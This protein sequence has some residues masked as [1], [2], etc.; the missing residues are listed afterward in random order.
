MTTKQTLQ[1]R[2]QLS[3]S[4][5]TIQAAT[6]DASRHHVLTY[7]SRALALHTL[8][9][10]SLRRE[11]KSVK[12]FDEVNPAPV[13]LK[14][15]HSAVGTTKDSTNKKKNST[16]TKDADAALVPIVHTL[17]LEYSQT[18][19]V[20][21]CVYTAQSIP[22]S[23]AKSKR[24]LSDQEANQAVYNVLFLEPA[25]L[26]KLVNYPG[27]VSHRLRCVFFDDCSDRLVLAV[28][29]KND[30]ASCSN[31]LNRSGAL[32]VKSH[33]PR[34]EFAVSRDGSGE[35]DSKNHDAEDFERMALAEDGPMDNH[36]DIL[37][38]SKREYK[39]SRRNSQSASVHGSA[40]ETGE[41]TQRTMLC[42]EKT[43]ASLLHSEMISLVC[44]SKRLTRLFGVGYI[45]VGGGSSA[46]VESSLVE[47]RESAEQRLELIRRVMVRDLITALTLSSC[48]TWLFTGHESG[49]LRV[50]SISISS[51]AKTRAGS[52]ELGS[53][54]L[55]P[56]MSTWHG[57]PVSSLRLS[58]VALSAA[59]GSE[60]RDQ[61]PPTEVMAITADR[62]SGV[63]KHW[64]FQAGYQRQ[65]SGPAESQAD[66]P[67]PSDLVARIDLVGSYNCDSQVP[68]K[69]SKPA[70]KKRT[71]LDSVLCTV[72]IFINIDMGSFTE[73]LLLV[74]R[75]DVI[76]V[77]KVQTVMHVLQQ[78]RSGDEIST[79]RIVEHVSAPKLV[80][81]SG[82][83][84]S[85]VRVLTLDASYQWTGKV[86]YL[87]QL[88]PP[89]SQRSTSISA[90]ECYQMDHERN[91]VVLGWTCGS[92]D[93]H[94]LDTKNRVGM[95]Q[96]P[97]L[98]AHVTAIGVVI[99]V[100]SREPRAHQQA[101]ASKCEPTRSW[102]DLLE[103]S[104]AG[105]DP[106]DHDPVSTTS[107]AEPSHRKSMVYIFA[108]TENGQIFGWKVPGS[109]N[110]SASSGSGRLLL[111]SKIRVDSAHS[112]HVVQFARLRQQQ[113]NGAE[114][115]V[116]LGADG[117]VK[118]WVVPSLS[119]L[120][121]INTATDGH[122]SMPSC[123]DIINS[124]SGDEKQ[125]LA[126]GSEDG[127]LA[128]WKLD[129]HK[130]SF[131]ELKVASHH[132]RRVTSITAAM[133]I[134]PTTQ[135]GSGHFAEFLSC[136]LD[137]TAIVWCIRE[138]R[139][140]E[141]RY[142]DIG[143][144]VVDICTVRNVAVA[145][146]AND[147]CAF[148][149]SLGAPLSHIELP[150]HSA[151]E[152]LGDTGVLSSRVEDHQLYQ[153]SLRPDTPTTHSDGE[154]EAETSTS[155]ETAERVVNVLR[156]PTSLAQ[157]DDTIT[158]PNALIT[159][160]K[161][162]TKP[163]AVGT[164][165]GRNSDGHGRSR[166]K[167]GKKENAA[168]HGD[169]LCAMLQNYIESHGTNDT[170]SAEY[171][172][173]FLSSQQLAIIK[174]PDFAIRKYLQEQKIEL[175]TRLNVYDACEILLAIQSAPDTRKGKFD[176]VQQ[177]SEIR[178]RQKQANK[179]EK[180]IVNR[181]A[182]VS[183]NILGEKFIRWEVGGNPVIGAE[184]K[185]P[186][187]ARRGD[188]Q[189][190]EST[191][192]SKSPTSA[193]I[194]VPTDQAMPP[195][196]EPLVSPSGIEKAAS[197]SNIFAGFEDDESP[198]EHQL[199][200]RRRRNRKLSVA[201]SIRFK[202]PNELPD[203]DL[204]HRL[205]LSQ[206]FKQHWSRGFCWCS[207]CSEL[208]VRWSDGPREPESA[209]CSDCNKK[210]HSLTLKK[211]DYKPHFSLRMVLGVIVEVYN[212]LMIPSHALLFKS[213]YKDSKDSYPSGDFS[214]HSTLYRV[215]TNKFGM[216]K[217]VEDKI[218]L[219]LLSATH[220]MRD[221]DAI[222]VFGEL[223]AMFAREGSSSD[224]HVPNEM[225]ALCVSCYSWFFSRAMV[226][227]GELIIGSGHD[228]GHNSQDTSMEIE[229]G[230]R[231]HW[232]FVN[233]ENA[234]LCAQE[235]LM[236]PLVSP[237]YLRS[238]L[239]HTGQYA[240]AYPT[241]PQ[242]A[243]DIEEYAGEARRAR[244]AAQWI[245]I[246]R[247][248]RL[249]VGE[250]KQ[251]HSE[252]R[253][254]E[255]T[256]FAQPLL[257]VTQSPP[258]DLRAEVIEKLRLI[259]SCFIFYDHEREGVMAIEDFTNILR[260]LRYLW[261]NENVT[262]EEAEA[263]AAG[264]V[265][266]TF[267]NT[268]L[269]ARRRFADVEGDGLI[270]Y[271]D[272]WAMLYIVGVRTLT[273]LKFRE[274]PSFCKDYKLEIAMDLHELLLCYM[275][276]SSTMMLP[277]GFQLG[278]SSLDQHAATQ[279]QRRVG[280]LHDGMFRMPKALSNSLSLQELLSSE[281]RVDPKDQIY[282]E[283]SAPALG[284]GAS[285]S[286]MDRFRP[287]TRDSSDT[288]GQQMVGAAPVVVGI[289]H[290]GP[291][292]K[293]RA[294]IS[295]SAI[296][297]DA[298]PGEAIRGQRPS[299]MQIE[300][301]LN[302]STSG[303]V[304]PA[305]EITSAFS[306]TYIQFPFVSPQQ[307]RLE[308]PSK[309]SATAERRIVG[310]IPLSPAVDEG[311]D[312]A[313][314]S[315]QSEILKEHEDEERAINAAQSHSVARRS[316]DE[317][318]LAAHHETKHA[319]ASPVLHRN[320]H[321]KSRTSSTVVTH[322]L[323]T[324]TK[325]VEAALKPTSSASV[326]AEPVKRKKSA[327]IVIPKIEK[328]AVKRKVSTSS[329][330]SEVTKQRYPVHENKFKSPE[331]VSV[332]T[333][334]SVNEP[335]PVKPL[336]PE[337]REPVQ[338]D[339]DP[340]V[341]DD[342]DEPGHPELLTRVVDPSPRLVEVTTQPRP[343][344]SVFDKTQLP[345]SDETALADTVDAYGGAEVEGDGDISDDDEA[346]DDNVDDEEV[347]DNE[348]SQDD[349]NDPTPREIS[350][351][352][353]VDLTGAVQEHV[354]AMEPQGVSVEA[355]TN[356][357][358]AAVEI[359]ILQ[360][361]Q[362]TAA[363]ERPE[364]KLS[365]PAV[366]EAPTAEVVFQSPI[367]GED[368][369][370]RRQSLSVAVE[371]EVVQE[372]TPNEPEPTK[373]SDSGY[374]PEGP[375][376]TPPSKTTGLV[377]HHSFRFSQ[378][379]AF[380]S[381]APVLNNPFRSGQWDPSN[382][383]DS[384]EER[385]IASEA[386]G[387]NVDS[388][389]DDE[390]DGERPEDMELQ[391]A[392]E[393]LEAYRAT[394]RPQMRRSGVNGILRPSLRHFGLAAAAAHHMSGSPYKRSPSQDGTNP[395]ISR[396]NTR[397]LVTATRNSE[398][399]RALYG[400]KDPSRLGEGIVVSAEAEAQMQQKWLAFFS[401][402]EAAMFSPLKQEIH[403]REEA[404]RLQE[405]LQSQLMKKRQDQQ[406][407]DTLR[408]Q[409]SRRESAVLKGSTSLGNGADK[410]SLALSAVAADSVNFRLRRMARE[411][412]QEIQNELQFGVSAQG[413]FTKVHEAQYFFFEYDPNTHGS[414][415]TLRLHVQRGEAE[416]FM[417]TDTKVPCVSDFMW[418]SVEKCKGLK[419]GDGQKLVLYSH[420][421][422]KVVASARVDSAR[423]G[424]D[425]GLIIPFF[426]SVVAVEPGT[427]FA[428]SIMT[429]GQK[430][431]P[432]RAIKMVDTLIEQFNELSKSFKGYRAPSFEVALL[433]MSSP[434]KKIHQPSRDQKNHSKEVE[435]GASFDHRAGGFLDRI[436]SRRRQSM[437]LSH[438]NDEHMSEHSDTV[439]HEAETEPD[440]A[441]ESQSEET[442]EVGEDC[443]S[444]QHLLESIGE[445]R[446]F[447]APRSKSFF[448]MGP[449]TDQ[450][451]FIQDEETNL[452]EAA[453]QYSPERLS[454]STVST[455]AEAVGSSA[456]EA[457]DAMMGERRLS[458]SSSTLLKHHVRRASVRKKIAQRLSPL[459][460]GAPSGSSGTLNNGVHSTSTPSLTTL[461][462]AKFAPK[463]VAY[464]LSSLD[465]DAHHL[466][467]S[468]AS[469][470]HP[471][472]SRK[473]NLPQVHSTS[474]QR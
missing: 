324:H 237:G 461:R 103:S 179:S 150:Q 116:S 390:D 325:P 464:S 11:I 198:S 288:R 346:Q 121:Y 440:D 71:L 219:F 115:L 175:K 315:W 154:G 17:S 213:A 355:V 52:Y 366:L 221:I 125:Y 117:M 408:L 7:D 86:C 298:L 216:Q 78:T 43:G 156:V 409:Q 223:L 239:M 44:G 47:W 129:Q 56:K 28:H 361:Q 114:R 435:D 159:S 75:D 401:N 96:D 382:D 313:A 358:T 102:G 206:C 360:P 359:F 328:D 389:F 190:R 143:A 228:L 164:S 310:R 172:T 449:T 416:V 456:Q 238:I 222:A 153:H 212:E 392:P 69:Q 471:P 311:S 211:Q 419:E 123:M 255:Q 425:D 84:F 280:G 388:E 253:V 166:K 192:A 436:E 234:L 180:T 242:S 318:E 312:A 27:P 396:R 174:R 428:L 9:L 323:E 160:S 161:F 386:A 322:A 262:A 337:P 421:L 251:Q 141:K 89:T 208:R 158:I 353:G 170:M 292:E 286:A 339:N 411:S 378:Q 119:I 423:G 267:E 171:L 375:E 319:V 25:T 431:E 40:E 4:D 31:S 274:I 195:P 70:M 462:V 20:F 320:D 62:D 454:K 317:L 100:V 340:V 231:T 191:P 291:R 249:L 140:D 266:L 371:K 258:T 132:E 185:K 110:D 309:Q 348:E 113:R 341:F 42:I 24:R 66:S 94:S 106:D 194:R 76:H 299:T 455:S 10:F 458:M 303:A 173:H 342:K 296:S 178:A 261:P 207:P 256:L 229:N 397:G 443:R 334:A 35:L 230:K 134:Q 283:G 426:V 243:G 18:T 270:C 302:K 126:V 410:A 169:E 236:Y 331:S 14:T 321:S 364:P 200:R 39:A 130:M 151:S 235:M 432:S 12:L 376:E 36:I 327:T 345:A 377:S 282:L 470:T 196:K 424:D 385:R 247:F 165:P 38:I 279:H 269:A 380:R 367:K 155:T 287:L 433:G 16:T 467:Q 182:V 73:S 109:F 260:K 104:V 465:R 72:S 67:N 152:Q 6:Y 118:V 466:H 60:D 349:S 184:Y 26:K 83:Q 406:I 53:S 23:R 379:P 48:S 19:D 344:A 453:S 85:S 391:L 420:D 265:S 304:N 446:S 55:E 336:I 474:S 217:V 225:V 80:V 41:E 162:T 187:E 276:R 370:L 293:P 51:G 351:S 138:D 422:A 248:L 305:G 244:R 316:T 108:G 354:V 452:V 272:F 347:M 300:G 403:G 439:K 413:E 273:L 58:V 240:Q 218:K 278:K 437:L 387:G 306:N 46:G 61:Q 285:V 254:A 128:V 186:T 227:N 383:S 32:G 374:T 15:F 338:S 220:Y 29:R 63:V 146:L 352:L 407:Q 203:H 98:N 326:A 92:V 268:I 301:L 395:G 226:I 252:F 214:I 469:V 295:V 445:K 188:V 91:F 167:T 427:A 136:S 457:I 451:E 2:H 417:S 112:A 472:P 145:A 193:S 133:R 357:P 57:H 77:L 418:R 356:S 412:C 97:H 362:P 473:I 277:R 314:Y 177:G 246:H 468:K 332:D 79:F 49:A 241:R 22:L 404:Q 245:E 365:T 233:L 3:C 448:L 429:S 93:I 120:G 13:P 105:Q 441:D 99:H 197:T 122:I 224:A 201:E 87:N 74:L 373:A 144:P 394:F 202:T 329:V 402:A 442:S 1:L 330:S 381:S 111:E 50:W 405:E 257:G 142:F 199:P 372:Q 333:K 139:V 450:F 307:S 384:D 415:L 107:D 271:L 264:E 447:G 294:F 95:L 335:T 181:K 308:I 215:F 147:I 64:R 250:W 149:F 37:Q 21:I 369:R 459:R 284:Q 54:P 263:I 81:L 131:A 232:Q 460:G 82:N 438:E 127:M 148:E 88:I 59:G 275:Q 45:S 290:M 210:I 189:S 183:F 135:Y 259:L 157:S 204:I 430:M 289:R 343:A 414:I 368:F 34:S 281:K 393:A 33:Q 90:M 399:D 5:V 101:T 68:G 400:E 398:D 65:Q 176:K 163:T 350:L 8:R 209:K 363:S 30:E 463:P 124:D 205:K 444:F 434:V 168:V 137:M 297:N